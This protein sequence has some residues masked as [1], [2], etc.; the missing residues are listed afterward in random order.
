[1]SCYA[2]CTDM[3]NK[4]YMMWMGWDGMRWDGRM[5]RDEKVI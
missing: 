4:A 2:C 5:K 1:M 3:E